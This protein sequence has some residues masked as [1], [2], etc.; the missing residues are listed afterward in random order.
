MARIILGLDSVTDLALECTVEVMINQQELGAVFHEYQPPRE[1]HLFSDERLLVAPEINETIYRQVYE[2][3]F[4]NGFLDGVMY[5]FYASLRSWMMVYHP[6]AI[7]RIRER[8]A[9]MPDVNYRILGDPLFHDILPFMDQRE[10]GVLFK[11]G[12]IAMKE[13]LGLEPV[14]VWLPECAVDES[15]L[16]A[17]IDA[18]Y[19]AVYLGD[20]QVENTG[21]NPLGVRVANGE[22]AVWVGNS[23]LAGRV[24]ND[25]GLTI[26]AWGFLQMIRGWGVD[27][28]FA[29][30]GETFGHHWDR[31]DGF[32][33]TVFN[34]ENMAARGLV[35]M[36]FERRMKEPR[37]YGKVK[38]GSS[39][40]CFHGVGRWTGECDCDLPT[41]ETLREKRQLFVD[42]MYRKNEVRKGL[43]RL[44]G[45]WWR[46][47]PGLLAENRHYLFGERYLD[48]EQEA[49]TYEDR[50]G[51]LPV[52]EQ[53]KRLA[54]AYQA[55]LVG[56]ISCSLYFGGE[57][58]PEREYTK[59]AIKA[60]DK[61]G[62]I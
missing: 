24:A 29:T 5:S 39:W 51:Y 22:I 27:T 9:R 11:A 45:D 40:S 31:R 52:S 38:N 21:S 14:T 23:D 19:G 6:E 37:S 2:P 30:D 25:G 48:E 36:D 4:V 16:R 7:T 8:L 47:M 18:G 1:V 32:A 41:A 13:D 57:R 42:L 43:D 53:V 59:R 26:D 12:R 33:K 50:T 35:P 28:L 60:V 56:G 34:R 49:R 58:R 61:L 55:C 15:V 20:R 3:T 46:W 62:V 54:R 44:G 10:S 17:A